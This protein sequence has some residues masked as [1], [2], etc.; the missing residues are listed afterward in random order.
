MNRREFLSMGALAASA[1]AASELNG[2]IPDKAQAATRTDSWYKQTG[3]PERFDHKQ[4]MF[5]RPL[6]DQEFRERRALIPQRP[7]KL[8]EEMDGIA[9]NYAG[10]WIHNLGAYA[11]S[12]GMC[13]GG[14]PFMDPLMRWDYPVQ[15]MTT[16]LAEGYSKDR[17][18]PRGTPLIWDDEPA[19]NCYQAPSDVLTRKV[20]KA[21]FFL[22]ASDVGVA[23]LNSLW[24]YKNIFNPQTCEAM[25]WPK[26]PA[27]FK[28]AVSIAV[29]MAEAPCR[30]QGSYFSSA[31]TGLGYS[32]MI[33]I[34]S[35][36][37]GFIRMLG[38]P[39]IPTGNDT[40]T[41]TPIAVDAGLGEVG[42]YGL[43]ISPIIGTRVRLATV[44]TDI[45]LVPDKPVRF[46]VEEFCETC[47]KC[48]ETCP[49]KAISFGEQSDIIR[50]PYNRPG[51]KR[52]MVDAEKCFNQWHANRSACNIC[53]ATCTFNKR[54]NVWFHKVV[55]EMAQKLNSGTLNSLM[56]KIDDFLGYSTPKPFDF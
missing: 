55:P 29:E 16:K 9:L 40:V 3:Q 51:F 32:R 27:Q 23:E 2:I 15:A 25:A 7:I 18:E 52:W 54:T 12:S 8:D 10:W 4:I 6:W 24:V 1:L 31:A 36:L 50:G 46:G 13:T 47:G 26:D 41:S 28:Y 44:L 39:A 19:P 49:S 30:D 48:A 14:W 35:S 45:P 53:L 33:E 11:N 5:L 56:A 21:A 42:R 22:G 34:S 20:K 43:L 38:Y 37:A 17:L